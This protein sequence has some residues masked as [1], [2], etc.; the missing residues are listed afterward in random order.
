MTLSNI[1]NRHDCQVNYAMNWNNSNAFYLVNH[2]VY[3]IVW[4]INIYVN[5]FIIKKY[6]I[7]RQ[8][9]DSIVNRKLWISMESICDLYLMAIQHV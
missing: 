2:K 3:S 4:K 5:L 6:N 8:I 7:K 1:I 9:S